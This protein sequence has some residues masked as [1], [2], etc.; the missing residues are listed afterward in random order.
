MNFALILNQHL[1]KRIGG[2]RPVGVGNAVK[3]RFA[4]AVP[5][6]FRRNAA[7]D[8]TETQPTQSR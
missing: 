5:L 7:I 8:A 3:P 4:D 2:E 1:A 6:R